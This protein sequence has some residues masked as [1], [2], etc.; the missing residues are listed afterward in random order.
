MSPC[1]IIESALI[2]VV[3]SDLDITSNSIGG[4]HNETSVIFCPNWLSAELTT[5]LIDIEI[6]SIS[7]IKPLES[8]A[9]VDWSA[10]KT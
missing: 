4:K 9:S 8:E 1:E 3:L 10:C 6:L 7:S 2:V 5:S